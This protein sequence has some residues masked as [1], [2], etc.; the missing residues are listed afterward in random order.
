MVTSQNVIADIVHKSIVTDLFYDSIQAL[1]S[2]L[3]R[4][5]IAQIINSR[6]F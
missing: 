5:R 3:I 2:A 6:E 1:R 4:E